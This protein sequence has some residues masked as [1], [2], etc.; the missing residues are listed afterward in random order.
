MRHLWEAVQ[1]EYVFVPWFLGP[2]EVCCY[3]RLTQLIEDLRDR[4]RRRCVKSLGRSRPSKQKSCFACASSKLKCDMA[5]PQCTRCLRKELTCEYPNVPQPC[6]LTPSDDELV[7]FGEPTTRL[8]VKDKPNQEPSNIPQSV[9][10]STTGP[11]SWIKSRIARRRGPCPNSD[12]DPDYITDSTPSQQETGTSDTQLPPWLLHDDSSPIA[13]ED[14]A[15]QLLSYP[16]MMLTDGGMPPFIHPTIFYHNKGDVEEPLAVAICCVAAAN[17]PTP[18]GR[19]FAH[20]LIESERQ[21]L[22][23]SFVSHSLSIEAWR[24]CVNKMFLPSSLICCLI[25]YTR[26]HRSRQ[27][28]SIKSSAS[29]ALI[30]ASVDYP[31]CTSRGYSR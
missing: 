8:G 27:C 5:T 12:L 6:Q 20:K 13:N 2:N 10:P 4:H 3:N 25:P 29:L 21:K 24:C 16:Q 7:S 18:R 14:L 9:S 22:V 23:A 31:N 30:E 26:L 15:Q 17:V 11:D 1:K 19:D 28:A